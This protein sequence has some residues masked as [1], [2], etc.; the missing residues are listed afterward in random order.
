MGGTAEQL[1]RYCDKASKVDK[2]FLEDY[3]GTSKD[4]KIYGNYLFF[5]SDRARVSE[6]QSPREE[7]SFGNRT[8]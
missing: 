4:P 3:N 7:E 6:K 5:L 1:Y 2:L 8:E